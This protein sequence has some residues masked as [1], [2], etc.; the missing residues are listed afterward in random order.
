MLAFSG[1][2]KSPKVQHPWNDGCPPLSIPAAPAE[3]ACRSADGKEKKDSETFHDDYILPQIFQMRN[4]YCLE[5]NLPL[6]W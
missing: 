3:A 4:I 5:E 6:D 1:F 2:Y